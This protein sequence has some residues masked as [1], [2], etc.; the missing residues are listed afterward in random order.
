MSKDKITAMRQ[1]GAVLAEIR[2]NL[3]AF[4]SVG[5]SFAAIEAEAQRLILKAG[6]KPSFSTVKGY[7]WATCIMKNEE[8][9]HGIPT[10][11]KTANNG[12]IIT[13]D[14]GL[15]NNGY[16]L[17]TTTTFSV[18]TVDD[19][20]KNFLAVGKKA[21]AKS[22]SKV[23][24]GVSVF[25]VSKAMQ[26]TVEK[27]GFDA[28]TQLTGH[29]V[30]EELHMVPSIPCVAYRHDKRVILKAGQTLAVEIM[31]AAG[32]AQLTLDKDGWTYKTIDNS[33]SAMFE[34]TILVTES[35]YE[36]LTKPSTSGI[37]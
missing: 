15:I 3:E 37:M 19:K 34:D 11:E 9:C 1:G 23:K 4:T 13:I 26:Q 18:G 21:L 5:L 25:E 35:G 7:H 28:V 16:H 29:G 2:N 10:K 14:V 27:V 33:L 32:S 24:E 8:M 20:T 36:V 31:Y 30:G 6:M 17:D 12:D 22:I